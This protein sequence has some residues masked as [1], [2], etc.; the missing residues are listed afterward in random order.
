[1][2]KTKPRH[3]ATGSSSMS[4]TQYKTAIQALELSQQRAGDWL[5]I[6]RRTSQGYALGEYPVPEPTA[7]LLR[8]VV[9]LKIDPEGRLE[10]ITRFTA[11]VVSPTPPYQVWF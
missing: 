9:K 3:A 8:L 2:T 6:G 1:M 11:S 4:K 10:N 7:K 5:G